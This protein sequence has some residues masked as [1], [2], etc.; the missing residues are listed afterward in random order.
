MRGKKGKTWD[1]EELTFDEDSDDGPVRG[2]NSVAGWADVAPGCVPVYGAPHLVPNQTL[3][4]DKQNPIWCQ[5]K[6]HLMPNQTQP[7]AKPTQIKLWVKPA[8]HYVKKSQIA[9]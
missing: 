1:N 9:D 5:T 4:G 6:P 2:G 8:R 7:D 3:H